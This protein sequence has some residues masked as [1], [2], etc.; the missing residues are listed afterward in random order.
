M[1]KYEEV[2]PETQE[3]YT[4]LIANADLNHSVNITILTN[5]KSKEIFKV[6]KANDILKYRTDDDIVIVLNEK[7]FEQ[8]TPEQR[9]IVAEESLAAIHFDKEND[10]VV[11]NKPDF[12]SFSGIISKYNFDTLNVLRETT[13][14]LY[15]KEKQEEDENKAL[16]TPTQK[17]KF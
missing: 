6:N 10:K 15:Q 14:S 1:A 16:K 5:N 7:I 4:K 9:I 3:L 17:P 2:Y 8:L 11:I 13:K 12:V